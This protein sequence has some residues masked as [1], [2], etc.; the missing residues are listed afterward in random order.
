[1]PD[2]Y[3]VAIV[4]A[5]EREVWPMVKNWKAERREYEGRSFK[6]FE[7]A[8]VALVCAGIGS[9]AARRATEAI[10]SLYQ[11]R[12][13][14]SAGFAGALDSRLQV[15]DTLV[16]SCV[17]DA[18]DGSRREHESG[19]GF[20]VTFED[21]ADAEQKAQLNEAFGAH[22]VDMEAAAVARC[23]E[24]HG[25]DFFACKVISDASDTSLP[26]VTQ[27]V[28]ADGSFQALRFLRHIA[29]RPWLWG[30]VLRLSRNSGIAARKL[31][32]ALLDDGVL[33]G[34]SFEKQ[35]LTH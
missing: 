29:F 15:G 23:A 19:N 31:C 5:L 4:A 25:L 33:K 34:A 21:V 8:S 30:S 11:P 2:S 16:P 9:E 17:I 35:V 18:K 14:I 10:I 24:A 3:K 7:N 28:A 32:Q 1:M 27:F 6:F 13:I 26:P 20:L 22:A 12:L